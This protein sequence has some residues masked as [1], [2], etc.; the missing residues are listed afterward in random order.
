MSEIVNFGDQS[1]EEVAAAAAAA[2]AAASRQAATDAARGQ[3]AAVPPE[4]GDANAGEVPPAEHLAPQ[5]PQGSAPGDEPSVPAP[6]APDTG[7]VPS[8]PA[9]GDTASNQAASILEQNKQLFKILAM[10]LSAID[11]GTLFT[12]NP[13][14]G[15]MGG[16]LWDWVKSGAATQDDA[17]LG[18]L[19]E[20][21]PE[22]VARFP[23]IFAQRAQVLAG[24]AV[25]VMDPKEVLAYE[26]TVKG[27]MF[28]AGVPAQFYDT[29]QAIQALAAQD[30][31]ALEV[32]SR[33]RQG[34]SLIHD[35]PKEVRDE[36]A[37]YFGVQGDSALAAWYLDANHTLDNIDRMTR[38]A[39]LGGMGMN[40]N[41]NID[42]VQAEELARANIGA[43]AAAQGF[44]EIDQQRPLFG[45][46]IHELED[47]TA[48][49]TGIAAA[50]GTP[51]S[52]DAR[53]ALAER[54]GTRAAAFAGQGG[55]ASDQRGVLGLTEANQ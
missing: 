9:G 55:A 21:T 30:I 50:F 31:S 11:L 48:E 4:T 16:K 29:P 20:A 14:T 24:K 28:R 26:D 49:G 52:A 37:N 32:D 7:M 6:V 38:A 47:L 25:H 54:R 44:S 10:R 35:A 1:P 46:Q 18:A 45:E 13:D 53:R 40:Y 51:G 33:I 2:A 15:E 22:F 36:F 39:S 23:A 3:Q 43:S 27:L 5:P 42:R 12:Y 34:F 8:T 41:L 17:V 19:V